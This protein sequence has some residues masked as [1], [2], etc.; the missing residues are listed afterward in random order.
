MLVRSLRPP[1]EGESNA[2]PGRHRN[3]HL[4][5]AVVSRPSAGGAG[6]PRL[7]AVPLDAGRGRRLRRPLRVLGRRHGNRLEDVR[8]DHP[9]ARAAVAA[10][11]G[12]GSGGRRRARRPHRV[13]RKHG[14]DPAQR[15]RREV[16]HPAGG[17]G[18]VPVS[19]ARPA[20]GRRPRDRRARPAGR[21]GRGGLHHRRPARQA[22]P[23]RGVGISGGV[24]GRPRRDVAEPSGR[25]RARTDHPPARRRALPDRPRQPRLPRLDRGGDPRRHERAAAV[26]GHHPGARTGGPRAG[27]P[28]RHR[29][30]R[31]AVAAPAA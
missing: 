6:V 9:D 2:Q 30:R 8:T 16:A 5:L 19:G 11:L 3:R 21:G 17:P 25:P 18:G 23:L 29:S 27:R 22:G 15:A 13:L 14:P 1:P 26:G 12:P 28:R 24:G 20:A 4:R 7:P 10:A 31:H